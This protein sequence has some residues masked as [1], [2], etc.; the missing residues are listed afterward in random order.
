M[1]ARFP[2]NESSLEIVPR[3]GPVPAVKVILRPCAPLPRAPVWRQPVGILNL[4]AKTHAL[5]VG[6]MTLSSEQTATIA[7]RKRLWEV[8]KFCQVKPSLT[9]WD[10]RAAAGHE[11][12]PVHPTRAEGS[13]PDAVLTAL[14]R[15]LMLQLDVDVAMI[16]L[17]DDHLQYFL[18][19]AEKDNT[20]FSEV[21]L[22]SSKWY[23]FNKV[24][25]HCGL[26]ERT[27]T[28]DAKEHPSAIY[29]ELDMAKN[30]LPKNLPFVNGAMAGFR[31]Y[32]G[33]PVVTEAGLGIVT[34]FVMDT[35]PSSGL[36]A[37]Q[38]RFLTETASNIMCQ[39]VQAV[40]ALEGRRVIRYRSTS[41]SLLQQRASFSKLPT[42]SR[43]LSETGQYPDSVS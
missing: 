43:K 28:I 2:R 19:G 16:S 8:R 26:C 37:A 20:N 38:R 12:L 15:G 25:H 24:I 9:V 22:E 13:C 17:L 31:H 14:V 1:A 6:R 29:E 42:E 4:V 27:I 7:N 21:T 18:A 11:R 23:A 10:R 35:R 40:Q 30:S 32:A 34:D 33:A 5:L 3:T 36:N 41:A 39:L